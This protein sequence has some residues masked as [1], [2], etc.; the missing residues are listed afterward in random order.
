M[1]AKRWALWAVAAVILAGFGA[2]RASEHE[3]VFDGEIS[4][5]QCALN[6]HSLSRSHEE[7]LKK[8]S[9]GTTAAECARY[10]VKNMGGVYVL[11]VK[12]KVYKLDNQDL[13]DKYAGQ[14]VKL[15]GVLDEKLNTIAVH[16]ITPVGD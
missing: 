12:N 14:K 15:R 8:K 16:S 1:K 3:Q 11:S 2:I 10:C 6:V 13:A 7:M 4:D 9:I 5:S